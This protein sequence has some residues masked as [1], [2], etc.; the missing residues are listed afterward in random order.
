MLEN[1][2]KAIFATVGAC[3]SILLGGIDKV[4]VALIFCVAL[5]YVT[6]IIK[7][8]YQKK[9]NS[10]I[11]FKGIAKKIFIFIVVSVAVTIDNY[12]IGS[13]DVLRSATCFFYI[14]NEAISILEN[15]A[16]CD[17]KLP[18]KLINILEQL[19]EEENI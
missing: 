3:L 5:D 14:A 10:E 4:I 18:T 17:V 19:K 6:G 2:I 7:A 9:L 13:G 11:G 1:S 8:I 12:I 16:A 15:A